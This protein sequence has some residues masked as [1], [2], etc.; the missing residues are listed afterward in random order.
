MKK[1]LEKLL[2]RQDLTSNEM[3]EAFEVLTNG[4]TS[5]A[6]IGAFLASLN[7]KGVTFEE[8][9][10][11]AR[12]MRQHA[13]FIDCAQQEVVDVVGT[14]GDKSNTFN[15]STT[16]CFVAAG[17]GVPMAKH[18]NR[19]A[20]SK[21]GAADVLG[22]LGVNLDA[23]ADVVEAAIAEHGIGFL[24]AAKM[25]PLMGKMRLIRSDLGIPTVFNLL[26]PLINPAGAKRQVL[27][28]YSPELTELFGAA[29][30]ELG[31]KRAM[32]V[33]GMDGLDELS[34]SAPS[35]VTELIDGELRTYELLPELYLHESYEKSELIGGTP[36]E[37]A[38]ILRAVLSGEDQG[39]KRAVT[40][41]NAGAVIYVSGRAEDLRE[42]VELAKKSIDSGSAM[43]KLET[44]IE[45]TNGNC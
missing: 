17:A 25:H 14:G 19:A 29:L 45:V 27:G 37:N 2:Q 30:R 44:L 11:A 16:S 1:Y 42:G 18:G 7:F 39:A 36:A 23:P 33:Y 32:V 5:H 13:V 24:F 26:G 28:V 8:L 22:E 38:A 3:A 21:C 15:I 12:L 40:L 4:K 35:R 41:L 34:C 9:S 6:Q 20:T 31:S 43:A 10:G